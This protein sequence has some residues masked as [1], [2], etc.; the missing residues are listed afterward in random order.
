MKIA[1]QQIMFN[2]QYQVLFQHPLVSDSLQH[3]SEPY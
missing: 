1:Q 2:P 3:P